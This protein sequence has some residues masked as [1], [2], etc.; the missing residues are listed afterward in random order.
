MLRFAALAFSLLFGLLAL[1]WAGAAPRDANFDSASAP[2]VAVAAPLSAPGVLRVWGEDASGQLG[3]GSP[4]M[5]KELP[6]AQGSLTNVIQ[7]DAGT[8]H[9]V[10]LL[11]DSSVVTWGDDDYGQL[12]DGFP[13]ADQASPVMVEGL[14]PVKAISAGAYF[15]LAL[16][17]N[18]EVRAW[19]TD[20][21]GQL[22]NGAPAGNR[23]A[24]VAVDGL[25][26]AVAISAGM[27]HAMA[28]LSDGTVVAW[29]RNY[30]GQIGNGEFSFDGVP[31]PVEVQGLSGVSAVSA[32]GYHSL[33]LMDDGS[34][35]SWGSDGTGQLGNGPS[36]SA[37][38]PLPGPVSGLSGVTAIDSGL[39]FSLA[40]LSDGDV[41]A[42]GYD[43]NGQ[44]GDGQNATV[45]PAPVQVSGLSDVRGIA[46]GSRASYAIAADS[47]VM[48]WGSDFYAQ[49]GNG[50]GD[51]SS[52]TPIPVLSLT[53][54]SGLGPGLGHAMAIRPLC[55]GRPATYAGGPG[56]DSFAGTAANDVAHLGAG[57]D[58][59]LDYEDG[60]DLV[61]GG[62]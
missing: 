7:V 44:L 28:L 21:E 8:S 17:K 12:G 62:S 33:A 52:T 25:S 4:L 50:P 43:S 48:A 39:Q 22:G 56:D 55:Q 58:G 16:L 27:E 59:F 23:A 40:L 32:A 60:D 35:M 49:L 20:G 31:A 54:V 51:G 5:R 14:G 24:P 61:C 45:Q 30:E 47:T 46:A 18:G 10:A 11:S 26:D 1:S 38:Q 57:D 3:N 34:L 41:W 6:V 53:G 37:D 13:L 9:S 29:G 19:G 2:A 15:T 42:W 36:S